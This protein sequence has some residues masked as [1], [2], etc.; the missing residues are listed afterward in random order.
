MAEAEDRESKTVDMIKIH[1]HRVGARTGAARDKV[2][3]YIENATD[4]DVQKEKKEFLQL[5]SNALKSNTRGKGMEVIYGTHT[6]FSLFL[7]NLVMAKK[8]KV[9]TGKNSKSLISL[10]TGGI[11]C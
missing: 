7:D 10:G 4:I 5:K 9:E 1:N 6:K 8:I 11:H 3:D 2:A